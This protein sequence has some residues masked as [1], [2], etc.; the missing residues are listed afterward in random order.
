MYKRIAALILTIATLKAQAQTE[1]DAVKA[2]VNQLFEGMRKSDTALLKAAFT[3]QAILQTIAKPKAGGTQVRTD[4]VAAFI[5][6]VGQPHAE[7]Y[8]ERISFGQ[9]LIDGDMASVW[10]PYK[11]YVG[12]KFSHCGVNSF[13][14]VKLEGKWK[15][16]Y[17]IDTRRREGCE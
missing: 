7:V 16:Q 1:A 10:T 15:I 4:E 9:V 11:F 2:T 6:S 14:L 13:Q 17:L 3:P 8:D 5:K 12:E